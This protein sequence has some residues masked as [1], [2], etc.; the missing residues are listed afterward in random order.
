MT[1]PPWLSGSYHPRFIDAFD[2]E[3]TPD[4]LFWASN[5][6]AALE[7]RREARRQAAAGRVEE[8]ARLEAELSADLSQS[9]FGDDRG[10]ADQVRKPPSWPR[11]WANS[12][13]L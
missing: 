8:L 2:A 13:L 11:S 7:T 1:P 6:D 5:F 4:S 12:S 10:A 3:L 9:L